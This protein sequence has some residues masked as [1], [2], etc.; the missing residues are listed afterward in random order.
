MLPIF[1]FFSLYLTKPDRTHNATKANAMTLSPPIHLFK[2]IIKRK[3]HLL[4]LVL[5]LPFVSFAQQFQVGIKAGLNISHIDG[6]A[7]DDVYGLVNLHGGVWASHD[8]TPAI[9]LQAEALVSTLSTTVYDQ[10]FIPDPYLNPR[11]ATLSYLSWPLLVRYKLSRK[12]LLNAG[13]QYSILFGKNKRLTNTDTD[14]F[15]NGNVSLVFGLQAGLGKRMQLYARYNPGIS[16]TG[17]NSN[18]GYNNRGKSSLVIQFGIGYAL[19][20]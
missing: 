16:S 5:A 17:Y 13:A 1:E 8:F 7:S 18:G 19:F 15:K 4:F 6:R 20:N 3:I 9:G 10:I 2:S 14:A 12:L 11:H